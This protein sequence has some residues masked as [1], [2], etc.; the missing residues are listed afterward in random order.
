LAPTGVSI[1]MAGRSARK[2]PPRAAVER[3][4]RI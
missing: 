3:N 4:L 2:I 1:T